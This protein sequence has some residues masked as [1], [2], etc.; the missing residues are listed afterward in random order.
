MAPQHGVRARYNFTNREEVTRAGWCRLE[1]EPLSVGSLVSGLPMYQSVSVVEQQER[2][3]QV[4]MPL[5]FGPAFPSIMLGRRS[6]AI[7]PPGSG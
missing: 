7:T 5:K 6:F 4:A 3:N 2:M 1:L